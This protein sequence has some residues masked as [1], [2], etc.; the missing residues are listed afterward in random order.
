MGNKQRVAGFLKV[1]FREAVLGFGVGPKVRADN[2][3]TDYNKEETRLL[4]KLEYLED[5]YV[6]VFITDYTKQKKYRLFG[7]YFGLGNGD[8][9]I[10]ALDNHKGEDE[11]PFNSQPCTYCWIPGTVKDNDLEIYAC[12]SK[13][14]LPWKRLEEIC[15]D[16]SKRCYRLG[17]QKGGLCWIPDCVERQLQSLAGVRDSRISDPGK[18]TVVIGLYDHL[19]EADKRAKKYRA[20]ATEHLRIRFDTNIEDEEGNK[21]EKI[22]AEDKL[23]RLRMKKYA[24]GLI[25][26][27]IN[28]NHPHAKTYRSVLKNGGKELEK[29]IREYEKEERDARCNMEKAAYSLVEWIGT[30]TFDQVLMDYTID[31]ANE[32][33]WNAICEQ[34]CDIL[35]RFGESTL[36]KKY[37]YDNWGNDSSWMRTFFLDNEA[38]QGV[39]KVTTGTASFL[40]ALGTVLVQ[41]YKERQLI[42]TLQG[43]YDVWF[44]EVSISFLEK[45]LDFKQISHFEKLKT[46]NVT[47]TFG[48]RLEHKKPFEAC[49]NFANTQAVK[50]VVAG[51]EALNFLISITDIFEKGSKGAIDPWAIMDLTGSFLDLSIALVEAVYAN[52]MTPFKRLLLPGLSVI[53]NIIDCISAIHEGN[54][55][56]Q[57]EDNDAALAKYATSGAYAVSAIGSSM[58]FA[59]YFT[60]MMIGGIAL[61][62]AGFV[63]VGVC[64]ITIAATTIWY[65][66][67]NEPEFADWLRLTEWGEK[68]KW[69][70]DSEILYMSKIEELN[71]FV[72]SF[73]AEIWYNPFNS[74][75][76]LRVTSPFLRHNTKIVVDSIDIMNNRGEKQNI[77]KHYTLDD[78]TNGDH[79]SVKASKEKSINIECNIKHDTNWDSHDIITATLQLDLLGNGKILLPS[80]KKMTTVKRKVVL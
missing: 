77:I 27:V 41:T 43:V 12:L 40:E 15:E 56:W 7:E 60:K 14:Q 10:G 25:N 51:V 74:I 16:P 17:T 5:K 73:T 70:F 67:A 13:I 57:V 45:K 62:P 9:A 58:I 11:R 32:S 44:K 64:G 19:S 35:Q 48:I 38:Y 36:T 50:S 39:R 30:K 47:S 79:I 49:G 37:I 31:P 53:N 42:E 34:Y 22:R 72:Y 54:K 28:S 24:A 33:N 69:D 3:D 66:F 6:Y 1:A 20:Y 75:A 29:C 63:V 4:C 68:R 59:S 76:T 52:A 23:E 8:F 26:D 2:I 46:S 65:I 78:K 21:P 80:S 55:Q 61:G 71:S 18:S